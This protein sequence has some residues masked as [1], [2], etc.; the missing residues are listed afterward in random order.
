[1]SIRKD[2]MRDSMES[3]FRRDITFPSASMEPLAG[4]IFLNALNKL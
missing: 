3:F 1:M 2:S 4:F